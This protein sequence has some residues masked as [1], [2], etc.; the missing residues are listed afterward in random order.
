MASI[1]GDWYIPSDFRVRKKEPDLRALF[2][3]ASSSLTNT[4]DRCD[5]LRMAAPRLRNAPAAV[6][7]RLSDAV[8]GS[9]LA[10]IL[11]G[12]FLENQALLSTSAYIATLDAAAEELPDALARWASSS[13]SADTRSLVAAFWLTMRQLQ[14]GAAGRLTC[15]VLRA[16]SYCAASTP[17]P[18]SLMDAALQ[19][20]KEKDYTRAVKRAVR[21]GLL[22]DD[23][24]SLIVHPQV[25]LLVRLLDEPQRDALQGI[26]RAI[27]AAG[28]ETDRPDKDQALAALVPHIEAAA[29]FAES[30]KLP[31]AG[32]LWTIVGQHYFKLKRYEP[33][34]TSFEHALA[35]DEQAYGSLHDVVAKDCRNLG[36]LHL[37]TGEL[38]TAKSFYERAIVVQET[39]HTPWYPGLA[40]TCSGLG[41]VLHAAGDL[42]GAAA[43]FE[44][45]HAIRVQTYYQGPK[46][47]AAAEELHKLGLV[48]R[49]MGDLPRAKACFEEALAINEWVNGPKHPS[50]VE[51]L[52][53]LG[54]TLRMQGDLEAA[55]KCF[56]RL[57]VLEAKIA[58]REDYA[59]P[60]SLTQMGLVWQDLGKFAEAKACFEQALANDKRIYG[61]ES[62]AVARDLNNL[63]C[64]LQDSGDFSA[65]RDCFQQALAIH[66]KAP[67]QDQREIA[68]IANNLGRV[69]Y[70]LNDLAGAK[71]CFERVLSTDKQIYGEEHSQIAS[72][73]INLGAVLH[74][75]G[76][77]EA[78][79]GCFQ[80]AL[81]ILEK[82]GSPED[83]RL[84]S[85]RKTLDQLRD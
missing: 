8:G 24:G 62:P 21:F 59:N 32:Q 69:L 37:E 36:A 9:P 30:E 1:F 57:I 71:M 13:D 7:K 12:L 18:K 75:M 34:K 15:Q 77:R 48:C 70:I 63:G 56:E 38:Q 16:A 40:N 2:D 85:V 23:D 83:P 28:K 72:D 76:D 33:A 74:E 19:S 6:M 25:A 39:I 64:V 68:I 82:A 65:A 55:R 43:C 80:R 44:R 46:H 54:Q 11:A 53:Q 35:A 31:A 79:Q 3:H 20:P 47:P 81:R 66:T 42:P 78:A 41:Q 5:L 49:D 29:G 10:L 45:A 51:N 17:I 50:V 73:A 84:E 4:E 26:V 60:L 58:G 67:I 52:Y 22:Q 14:S 61:E 27:L